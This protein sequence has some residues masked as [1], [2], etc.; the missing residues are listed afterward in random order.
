MA[1]MLAA[2]LAL[3]LGSVP[4]QA[5]VECAAGT[6]WHTRGSADCH[7]GGSAGCTVAT[8]CCACHAD[9][10]CPGGAKDQP[11]D[12]CP[13]GSTS[14]PMS[15]SAADCTGGPAP[16][17]TNGSFSQ[18]HIAYTGRPNEFSVDFVGGAG[19]TTTYTSLDQARWTATAAAS[20]PHPTIGYMS[21]GILRFPGAASGQAAYYM[22]GDASANSSVWTVTPNITARPE[23]FAV[24]AVRARVQ[25]APTAQGGGQD[26][27]VALACI[28]PPPRP[29]FSLPCRILVTLTTCAC[30]I[31]LTRLP[32]VGST[33]FCT[34]ATGGTI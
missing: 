3:A 11:E 28:Y 15:T 21:A 30:L 12:A 34:L 18:V 20:F 2:C 13:A 5:A 9:Y 26:P 17:P 27:R 7:P 16:P 24:Y 4:V 6:Y 19:Q 1:R 10:Y 23:V 14:P 29:F 8:C 33:Q 31:L 32:R 25:R 22:V